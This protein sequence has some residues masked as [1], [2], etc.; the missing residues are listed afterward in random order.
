MCIF[1]EGEIS[2]TGLLLPFRRG[3]QRIVKGRGAPILPV[4]LDR[5]WGSILAP[6]RSILAPMRGKILRIPNRFPVPIT[7]SIGES[8]AA[9]TS[10]RRRVPT[11]TRTVLVNGS[12]C[13]SHTWSSSSSWE[14]TRPAFTMKYRNNANSLPV[15]ASS[16]SARVATWRAVSRQRSPTSSTAPE[17]P[18]SRRSRLRTRALSSAYAKGF[19][20]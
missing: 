7:V 12:A 15:S 16:A 2:R 5:V 4:H 3:L 13:S 10:L 1:A 11:V 20:R 18:A 8:P 14:M 6:M 9:S 19:T 17:V